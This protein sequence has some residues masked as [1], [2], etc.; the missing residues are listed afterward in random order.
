MA[1]T[2]TVVV[3]AMAKMMKSRNKNWGKKEEA[4]V[5]AAKAIT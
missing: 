5:V 4:K 2:A 3:V 1:V